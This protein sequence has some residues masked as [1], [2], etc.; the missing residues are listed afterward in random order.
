[1]KRFLALISLSATLALAAP[2]RADILY[3]FANSTF[4]GRKG[5]EQDYTAGT[6]TIKTYGYNSTYTASP[7]TLTLGSATRLY[8]KYTA[9]DPG[10]TGLGI[11]SDPTGNHEITTNTSVKLD[12][13]SVLSANPNSSVTFTIGSVQSGE[14]FA[15]FG[16]STSPSDFIYQKTGSGSTTVYEYTITAAQAAAAGDVFYVTATHNNVLIN[17]VDVAA[18]PEPSSAI[19]SIMGL[20][21]LGGVRW[22][23][24][25]SQK[26]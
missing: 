21:F 19:L 14:G 12:M 25:R 13:T 8:A 1:M 3:T 11:N 10:E 9:G 22:L 24:K 15:I 23:R 16:G 18:V 4:N 17:T 20:G 2:A 6:Y 5:T 26:A 7:K